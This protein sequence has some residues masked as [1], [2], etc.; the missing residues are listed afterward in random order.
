[1][2]TC[3]DV[4]KGIHY[5]SLE[6]ISYSSTFSMHFWDPL[7]SPTQSQFAKGLEIEKSLQSFMFGFQGGVFFMSSENELQQ[8]FMESAGFQ[9]FEYTPCHCKGLIN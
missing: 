8:R 4:S 3:F 6:N 1:M 5:N 2:S 9:G 7:G